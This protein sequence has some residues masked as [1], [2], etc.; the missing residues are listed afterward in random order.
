VIHFPRDAVVTLDDFEK[1]NWEQIARDLDSAS[2]A[3]YWQYFS[4]A[5]EAELTAGNVSTGKLLWLLADISSLHV[6]TRTQESL[7]VRYAN[8]FCRSVS[9][10]EIGEDD[11][12]ILSTVA[13]RIPLARLRARIYFILWVA[14]RPRHVTDAQDAVESVLPLPTTPEHWLIDFDH[15]WS[16]AANCAAAIRKGKPTYAERVSD[17]LCEAI[18]ISTVEDGYHA[19][20]LSEIVA[21]IRSDS[22]APAV[23]AKLYEL[24]REFAK[25]SDV[26]K[27]G[28]YFEAAHGW[29]SWL[30]DMDLIAKCLS[31]HAE[32]LEKAADASSAM[33]KA[34]FLDRAV[35]LL[36]HLDLQ[37]RKQFDYDTRIRR[38]R[39]GIRESNIATIDSMTRI[40]TPS[41]DVSQI[42]EHAEA[43]VSGKTAD[44]AVQRFANLSPFKN[45]EELTASAERISRG[46]VLSQIFASTHIARDGRVVAR[47]PAE[48]GGGEGNFLWQKTL[49]HY[50][51]H[52]DITVRAQI[53]PAL[54]TLRN[55]HILRREVFANLCRQCVIVPPHQEELLGTALHFGYELE[56]AACIHI[57]APLMESLVRYNIARHG[58]ET[59]VRDSDGV[60]SEPALGTLLTIPE[61]KTFL[62][63]NLLLEFKALFTDPLGPNLRNEVAHGL[64]TDATVQSAAAIYAWWLTLKL[65]VLMNERRVEERA[66]RGDGTQRASNGASE[67]GARAASDLGQV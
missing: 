29:F 3:E 18:A 62:G 49:E 48:F 51:L 14:R 19:L 5:T 39:V 1:V 8:E 12:A 32:V 20:W 40:S 7:A 17:S 58:G 30:S 52:L 21:K 43:E 28:D 55:E 37:S 11:L 38:I 53:V 56:F 15:D 24:A 2:F 41:I 33:L 59:R 31:D 35:D 27:A 63:E 64:L 42:I 34:H 23:A 45:F 6:N 9:L 13:A 36:R 26:H 65:V 46:A 44:E 54:I 66:Q 60:D 57:L 25:R 50:K 10:A 16:I 47:T 4:K 22:A 61:A 67:S